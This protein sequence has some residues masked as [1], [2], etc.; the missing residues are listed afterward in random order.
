MR[1][2][3]ITIGQ[4]AHWLNA[5]TDQVQDYINGGKVQYLPQEDGA[6]TVSLNS[7]IV[8]AEALPENQKIFSVSDRPL[9]TTISSRYPRMNS[10]IDRGPPIVEQRLL[11]PRSTAVIVER[12][13]FRGPF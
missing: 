13:P 6:E 5:T 8:T 12:R 11:G 7:V 10:R 9:D 2:I 1:D 3:P 4:A